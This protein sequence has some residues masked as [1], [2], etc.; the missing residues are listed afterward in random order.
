MRSISRSSDCVHILS[1]Y[2]YAR[3][4]FAHF[5]QIPM[6]SF[7]LFLR[8]QLRTISHHIQEQLVISGREKM[9]AQVIMPVQ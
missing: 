2:L 7:A 1:V 9:F 8:F 6:I 5:L 3:L 4:A